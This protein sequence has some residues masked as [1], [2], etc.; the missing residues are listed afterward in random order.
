MLCDVSSTLPLLLAWKCKL[1]HPI[2]FSSFMYIHTSLCLAFH[3][4]VAAAV[5]LA[6]RWNCSHTTCV[7]LPP[8]YSRQIPYVL[9]LLHI[10]YCLMLARVS[11]TAITRTPSRMMASSSTPTSGFS[12]RPAARIEPI[13]GPTV[14]HEFTPLAVAH[15]AINLGQGFPG[16]AAPDF[17]KAAGCDAI[18]ADENQYT[19]SA[20]HPQL[21][22]AL[23]EYYSSVLGRPIDANTNVAVC[24]G[25]TQAM[26]A[27]CQAYLEPGDEVVLLEPAFDIYTAQIRMAGATPVYVPLSAPARGS[28][29]WRFDW[30]AI[31]AAIT[32]ATKFLV[33]N[34]PHNPTGTVC[35]AADIEKLREVCAAH[36]GLMLVAD[37]VYEHMVY[38]D[39]GF[40][41]VA[42]VPE[43]WER[44][45]TVSSAGKTFSITGWK[46]GWV[47]GPA[48]LVAPVCAVN[49]WQHFS[50]ATPLQA[51]VARILKASQEPYGEYPSY[52][53]WLAAE[54][55]RKR[56]L[57][58]DGLASVGLTPCVPDAGFFVLADISKIQ[59][60]ESYLAESTPACPT[61]TRDWAVCRWLTK[62]IG[63]AAIPPSA[64]YSEDH[65]DQAAGYA[66]FAFCK[67]DTEIS[68]AITRL[69]RVQEFLEK[70]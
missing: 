28:S 38:T 53:A 35:T 39:A 37:E 58:C 10:F 7:Y 5:L 65:K 29:G 45:L 14:W 3:K 34:T 57:L 66:R 17:A 4:S 46:I 12:P 23:G 42:A 70:E 49:A 44:T 24:V 19:R 64:F 51:A 41:Q 13:S 62:D 61:M 21:V 43:L 11:R 54:Y 67:E 60:P 36:P 26:F 9:L 63:V 56:T 2:S 6:Q 20:G 40:A 69:V 31:S 1:G 27:I 25:A 18:Q 50:V 16:W 59:V 15:G 30:D 55:R 48:E 33:L 22:Q 8:C 68:E 32:P 52:F 47:V